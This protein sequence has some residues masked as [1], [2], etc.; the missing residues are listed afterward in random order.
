MCVMRSAFCGNE[1]QKSNI[2]PAEID[3]ASSHRARKQNDP[4]EIDEASSHRAGILKIKMTC[5]LFNN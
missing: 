5:Q 2:N 3:E 1:Y 4:D